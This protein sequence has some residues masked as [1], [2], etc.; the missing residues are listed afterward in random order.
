MV[1][2]WIGSVLV[3]CFVTGRNR[4]ERGIY[5]IDTGSVLRV[6]DDVQASRVVW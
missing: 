1:Y 6:S 4:R 3:V 5:R 2:V